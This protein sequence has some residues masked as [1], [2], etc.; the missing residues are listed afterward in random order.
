MSL[1]GNINLKVIGIVK[2]TSLAKIAL[3]G[4][5]LI[6]VY[7]SSLA[8]MI[9]QWEREDYSYCYLI[10]FIVLYLIWEKRNQLASLPSVSSWKGLIPF[11]LGIVFFWLGELGGEYFTLY[12]SFWLV[13]V[14]ICWMHLGWEKLK[15]IAFP[16]LFSLTM[17]PFPN[18]LHNKISVNLKLISSQLG[19]AMMQLYGMSAYREGNVID[20][21]F[22]QL[23]VVDACNGLRYLFPLIILGILLAYFFRA[24]FWKKAILVISTLPLSIITNSLRIALT[25]ILY[26]VWGTKVAEGFFHG[27]SGWFIFMF[28]LGVL[29]LEMWILKKVQGSRFKVQDS[30]QQE[31]GRVGGIQNS[32]FLPQF[33]VTVILLGATLALSQ[34]IEFREKI[35]IKK[36][37]DRFPLKVGEWS[38]NRQT[39]E[40][41][42][43][44]ALDLSDYAII[45]YQN[46]TGKSVNFYVAYYESQRKGESIH[47]PATCLPGGGWIFKQAGAVGIPLPANDGGFMKVN[48]AFMQKS[49][50]KQLSYYWF[51]QR[52]RILTNAYQLKIFAFWDALTRQRTDG[53]MVRVITSVHVLEDLEEAEK[54]LQGFTREIV[55]V[56]GE[57][58]PD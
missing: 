3:Y 35:P 39:M 11:I 7:Y 26:E 4:L 30:K 15:T 1:I 55:P 38:G 51:P 10:P 13:M 36:S 42:F 27:F 44:D 24:A 41:K 12:I 49:G 9:S 31:R 54:R 14:G 56:L 17:F 18:F 25:G 16:L 2:P 43:I 29:L 37:F 5:L 34:G 21:G 23:Q 53:A 45:E 33:V 20:L 57:F 32:F 52:G 19:V 48:R 50:Y 47:S 46:S 28:S 8:Y 58:L 22:T 6:G 40:Q